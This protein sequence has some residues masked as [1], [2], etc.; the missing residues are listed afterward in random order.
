MVCLDTD[1]IIALLRKEQGAIEKLK[2]IVE[3]EERLTTTPIT[4]SE[5]FKGAYLS[6]KPLKEVRRVREFLNY[7]EILEYS[8]E[9]CERY[10]KIFAELKK[11]GNPIGDFDA[12]IGSIAQTHNQRLITRNQKHF[13]KIH[14]LLVEDW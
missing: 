5:L 4:A 13:Q 10:G 9:A 8:P 2:S 6:S 3:N 7:L 11:E 12:I 1:F 14:G